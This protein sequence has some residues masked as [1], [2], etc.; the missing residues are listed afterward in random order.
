MSG[1]NAW[2]EQHT[3]TDHDT[4]EEWHPFAL[5][6]QANGTGNPTREKAINGPKKPG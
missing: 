3:N 6:A 1:M 2:M 5:A 4:V